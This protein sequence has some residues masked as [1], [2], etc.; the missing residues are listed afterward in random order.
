MA[1]AHDDAAPSG[2]AVVGVT[3]AHRRLWITQGAD[4]LT[5]ALFVVLGGSIAREQNPLVAGAFA[6]GGLL[7]VAALKFGWVA[8]IVLIAG[9]KPRRR[10]YWMAA[11]FAAGTGIVGAGF[12]LAACIRLAG[13]A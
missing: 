4:L 1:P 6:V 5:L 3:A 8:A 11:T 12:N 13:L 2:R 7:A 10:A 9:G